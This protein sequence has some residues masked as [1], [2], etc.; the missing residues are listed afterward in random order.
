MGGRCFCE[1]VSALSSGQSTPSSRSGSL[2]EYKDAE[3]TIEPE[4]RGDIKALVLAPP[5]AAAKDHPEDSN[6]IGADPAVPESIPLTKRKTRGGRKKE[7]ISKAAHA[8]EMSAAIIDDYKLLQEQTMKFFSEALGASAQSRTGGKRKRHAPKRRSKPTV[9]AAIPG[10]PDTR[11]VTHK[12]T[13]DSEANPDPG[14]GEDLV[15]VPSLD[16]SCSP[17]AGEWEQTQA[18]NGEHSRPIHSDYRDYIEA[19]QY[20]PKKQPQV[21]YVRKQQ[22]CEQGFYEELNAEIELEVAHCEQFVREVSS[23][24]ETVKAE[25]VAALQRV[26]QGIM[27][28]AKIVVV[29]SK[30]RLETYGSMAMGLVTET[31]DLD[32]AVCGLDIKSRAELRGYIH[33]A[34]GAL[35][36]LPFVTCCE[37]IDTAR[38]PLIKLVLIDFIIKCGCSK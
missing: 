33:V 2:G 4:G 1:K 17:M 37:A 24:C 32:V 9:E 23:A 26:F 16:R 10:S 30:I 13:A 5:S 8:P 27:R 11:S 38:V 36:A 34:K 18:A 22:Q 29:D 35:E 28:A 20:K 6:E 12:S 25:I 3:E 15:F 31:S 7:R 19:P 21:R 14:S